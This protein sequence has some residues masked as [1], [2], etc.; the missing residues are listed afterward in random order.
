MT[1][2]T[3]EERRWRIST[4]IAIIELIVM[5]IS[6][7]VYPIYF[8][9]RTEDKIIVTLG[10]EDVDEDM[11]IQ[12]LLQRVNEQ[13]DSQNKQVIALETEK[14]DLLKKI[15]DYESE[16]AAAQRNAAIIDNAK[17][18]ATSENYEQAVILLRNVTNRTPSMEAL[19]KDYSEKFEGQVVLKAEQLMST[20][21][22]DDALSI[23]NSALKI[24]P[25]SVTLSNEYGSIKNRYPK[26]FSELTLSDQTRYSIPSQRKTDTVGN[27][28]FGN[29]GVIYAEGNDGYGYATYYLGGNY[30]YLS[31]TIAVSDESEE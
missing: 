28:Y 3:R 7:L 29:I 22:Y 19:L 16:E 6:Y 26:K 13:I 1:N 21:E 8:E 15:K 30:R 17:S 11:S 9:N 2:E 18:L 12:E 14:E 25:S 23:V 4:A 20:K 24:L 5:I 27:S 31:L 10:L